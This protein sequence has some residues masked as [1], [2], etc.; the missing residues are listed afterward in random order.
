[1][2]D[3]PQRVVDHLCIHGRGVEAFRLPAAQNREHALVPESKM[4]KQ[5]SDRP[6]I[7]RG[8]GEVLLRQPIRES[9]QSLARFCILLGIRERHGLL[10]AGH[11][12]TACIF[13]YQMTSCPP[14]STGQSYHSCSF[15]LFNTNV[16][17]PAELFLARRSRLVSKRLRLVPY[18]IDWTDERDWTTD[19]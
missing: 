4:R 8:T 16:Q 14:P 2:A 7:I 1:M 18:G 15:Y 5:C 6:P 13:L 17:G 9:D 3:H 11:M 19:L 12:Y 10:L